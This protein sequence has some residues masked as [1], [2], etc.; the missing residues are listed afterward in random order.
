[1]ERHRQPQEV[2]EKAAPELD[3]HVGAQLA[4]ERDVRPGGDGLAQ[5][6]HGE[7]GD[8]DRQGSRVPGAGQLRDPVDPDPDQPRPGQGRDVRQHDQQQDRGDPCPV[9]AQQVLQ[10]AP[11]AQPQQRGQAG[12]HLV[13]VLG[14]DAP[15]VLPGRRRR[16][17]HRRAPVRPGAWPA[18]GL[19][20][21]LISS[22]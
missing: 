14:R 3:H 2:G 20:V 17:G 6:G 9:R 21:P 10:Q 12:R 13:D 7:R 19:S 1:V 18:S 5:D 8:D 22:R 16:L 15:P 4:H 11:A